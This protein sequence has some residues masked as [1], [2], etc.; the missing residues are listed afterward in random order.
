VSDT[1]LWVAACRAIETERPDALF[2]DPLAARL[3]GERGREIARSMRD[4]KAT[5]WSVAIRTVVVDGFLRAAIAGGVDAIVNLG[6]GLD[7]RPYR[8]ELPSSLRWIEVDYPDLIDTKEDLLRDETPWCQL[9]RVGLDLADRKGRSALFER[10]GSDG[11]RVLV[12]TEGVIPYLSLDQAA[13]LAADLRARPSF[14]LWVTDYF[15]PTLLRTLRKRR[16]LAD[17]PFRFDPPDWEGFFAERGWRLREMRYL[18]EES[19]RLHRRVP[20]PLFLELIRPFIPS[21]GRRAMLRMT[22][23]ATLEPDGG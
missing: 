3:A 4:A 11:G 13:E 15:S 8:M 10:I 18:G 12:L 9:E 2:R 6:A 21:S 14:A 23:Y 1:A 19:V 20:M 16:S 22:G 5:M 17:A 7:T